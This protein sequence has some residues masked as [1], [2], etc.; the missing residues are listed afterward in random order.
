MLEKRWTV[1]T[2]REGAA[3]KVKEIAKAKG[4][5]VDKYINDIMSTSTS[6]KAGWSYCSICGAKLNFQNLRQI[7]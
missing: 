2:V 1:L 6:V 4:L 3:R 7:C 5:T